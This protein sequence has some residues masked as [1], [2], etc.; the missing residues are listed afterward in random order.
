[1]TKQS[2]LLG[3]DN[4]KMS[5][6]YGN[7]IYLSDSPEEI[8]SKVSRMV[9]DP[10]RIKLT[11]KGHPDICT[12]FS[13]C[14]AFGEGSYPKELRKD[15][16]DA[17]LGCTEC[18]ARLGKLLSER[19]SPIREKRNNLTDSKVR[20]ILDEG[21]KRAKSVASHTMVEVRSAINMF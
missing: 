5:K 14:S 11:D 20:D 6:S 2:K 16:E 13:Y 21:A 9:T 8:A 10:E 3:L 17:K 18:K 7:C 1:M 4:R 19:L 12:V 15:C